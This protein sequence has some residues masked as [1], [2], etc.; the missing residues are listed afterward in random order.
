MLVEKGMPEL[1]PHSGKLDGTL[2]GMSKPN[3][4]QNH[5]VWLLAPEGT[6]QKYIIVVAIHFL[7]R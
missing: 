1:D 3:N 4:S 7:H 5:S 2:P 6:G